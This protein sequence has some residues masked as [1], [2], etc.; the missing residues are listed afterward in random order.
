MDELEWFVDNGTKIRVAW[1][2]PKRSNGII[3]NFTV[4]Y[5]LDSDFKWSSWETIAVPGNVTSTTLPIELSTNRYVVKVKAATKAGY[6]EFSPSITI[7]SGVAP[8]SPNSL[9]NDKS[10]QKTNR[11]KSLGKLYLL[12]GR[13]CI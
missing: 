3:Q 1:K 7:T 8:K 13:Y 5:S 4:F 6:G 11:D 9:G 12:D 10:P 2:Q